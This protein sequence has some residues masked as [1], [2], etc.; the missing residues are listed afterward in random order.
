MNAKFTDGRKPALN[1][2]WINTLVRSANAPDGMTVSPEETPASH[3]RQPASTPTQT[4]NE[5]S[6]R[7]ARATYAP[8][9][10]DTCTRDGTEVPETPNRQVEL[11]HPGTTAVNQG[12]LD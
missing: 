11:Q 9:Y 6:A 7:E 3:R 5:I 2:D 4:L 10:V 1:P 8:P 12:E